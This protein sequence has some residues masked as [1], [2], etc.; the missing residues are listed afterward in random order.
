[1]KKILCFVTA[2][3]IALCA[4]GCKGN[5]NTDTDSDNSVSNPSNSHISIA[6]NSTDSVNPYEA[7]TDANRYLSL[8][9]Y[10]PL[11]KVNNSFEP[12]YC[13]AENVK[14]DGNKCT[15]TLVNASFSD[16]SSLTADDVVYSFNAAKSG[17]QK[18]AYILAGIKSAKAVG[19]S[20]EFTADKADPY[21]A[22][23]LTFPIF[24]SGSDTQKNQDNVSLPP[25]GCGRYI[26]DS[27]QEQLTA[28][29][30]WHGGDLS[31]KTIRLIDAPGDEALTH[32]ID[33]G[34]VDIY[35]T[36]LH[37]CNILRMS[38]SRMNVELNNI[39]YIGV[40][41][42]NALLS[43]NDLRQA[44]S[45]ALNRTK[46]CSDAYF[47]NAVPAT[48]FFNPAWNAASGVQSILLLPNNNIAIE[49]LAKIG[50]NSR[51]SDG[52]AVNSAGNVLTLRLLVNNENQFRNNAVRLIVNQLSAVGIKIVLEQVGFDE[53]KS[54]LESRNFDLYLGETQ[55]L[56]N[57]DIS[58]LVCA[59][60]S[61]AYGITETDN[62]GDK[63]DDSADGTDNG[64]KLTLSAVI[65]GFY[66]GEYTIND[67]AALAV[68]QMP[69]IPVCYRTG[70]LFCSDNIKNCDT[71]YNGDIYAGINKLVIN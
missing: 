70:I 31:V 47:N 48:G 59:G 11:I 10:D 28:N 2:I 71:A 20:V 17:N 60:G 58:Q 46:I 43:Q 62:T 24:K 45:A 65:N 29:P 61:A 63:A 6:Y 32:V 36:D 3:C 40:N 67:V 16:G 41:H 26:Y 22:N 21:M 23:L 53:Y 42:D 33:I 27:A 49:N 9:L 18:Y 66:G 56:D 69:V 12:E 30:N 5:N 14:I 54:R 64:D 55:L 7:K 19:G 39:V 51:N 15:V 8:L 25:I 37:D 44:I 38:G 4:A 68:S 57:M 34:A 13:L 35:Y 1:M 52:Y 50:Y